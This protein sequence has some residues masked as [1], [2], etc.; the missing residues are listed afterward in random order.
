MLM[1]R[2]DLA[3]PFEDALQIYDLIE[4]D[5]KNLVFFDCDHKLPEEYATIAVKWFNEHLK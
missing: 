5:S 3:C 2:S 1:G 4:S